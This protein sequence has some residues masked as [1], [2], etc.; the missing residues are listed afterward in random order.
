MSVF[1]GG[2]DQQKFEQSLIREHVR[3]A[4]SGTKPWCVGQ[5]L[6]NGTAEELSVE[7]QVYL[8]TWQDCGTQLLSQM[9]V[10]ML[11]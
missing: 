11:L 10:Q 6:W 5:W 2:K 1:I 7:L 4:L 3:K 8:S 9:P